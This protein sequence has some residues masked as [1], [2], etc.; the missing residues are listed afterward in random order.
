MI[1]AGASC[2]YRRKVSPIGR[3][4]NC[5]RLVPLDCGDRCLLSS[6]GSNSSGRE[7]VTTGQFNRIFPTF[8]NFDEPYYFREIE[9]GNLQPHVLGI[10]VKSIIV[11]AAA[12]L[13]LVALTIWSTPP[14]VGKAMRAVPRICAPQP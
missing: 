12:V 11:I 1:A 8:G 3:L 14:E 13:M 2:R 5:P 6:S 4:R 9:H 7:V 10:S